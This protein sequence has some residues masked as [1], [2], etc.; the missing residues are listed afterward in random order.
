MDAGP[1]DTDVRHTLVARGG[2]SL[3][4]GFEVSSILTAR[5][6]PP[7][8]AT[9]STPLVIFT[10]YEPRNRRRGTGFFSWDV[11]LGRNTR[12][13]SRLSAR[14]FVEAFNVLNHRNFSTYVAN[15]S[16]AQFGRPSEAFAPR[17]VQLGLRL[18][19]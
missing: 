16:S 19:F 8:A 6:P 12:I 5:S 18:D 11:R 7:Y 17:R 3:P 4:L 14:L 1:C 9:T 15:V 13:T 2:A 10:R